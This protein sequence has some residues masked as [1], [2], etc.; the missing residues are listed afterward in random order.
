MLHLQSFWHASSGG[1][2]VY[3]L[4]HKHLLFL[5]RSNWS[6]YGVLGA[7]RSR[8]SGA[9]VPDDRSRVPRAQ[10]QRAALSLLSVS[11]ARDY[12][13]DT[14]IS[15]CSV[16]SRI[17]TCARFYVFVLCSNSSPLHQP[18]SVNGSAKAPATQSHSLVEPLELVKDARANEPQPPAV[19]FHPY[20]SSLTLPRPILSRVPADHQVC[21]ETAYL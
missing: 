19:Q 16:N 17:S 15:L 11:H 10:M 21:V 3:L 8:G 1:L 9:A 7:H 12:Y 18:I 13:T 5:C 6:L 2:E 4:H 20:E 14:R